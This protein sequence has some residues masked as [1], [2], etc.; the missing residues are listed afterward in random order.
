M[1]GE[2]P[3]CRAL[4]AFQRKPETRRWHCVMEKRN[5]GQGTLT[6][7]ASSEEC[8]GHP[9]ETFLSGNEVIA[10]ETGF[11]VTVNPKFSFSSQIW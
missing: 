1:L 7:Q 5:C 11:E 8:R 4:I 6:I 2:A 10:L 3:R 9:T